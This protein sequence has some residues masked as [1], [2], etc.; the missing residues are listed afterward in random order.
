VPTPV[1]E[2]VVA[3]PHAGV[4]AWTCRF[5][6]VALFVDIAGFT[7]LSEALAQWGRRGTEELTNVLNR[8]FG[9]AIDRLEALGG[10]VTTFAGD[11]LTALFPDSAALPWTPAARALQ[12]AL[13]LQAGA[14]ALTDLSTSAGSLRLSVKVGLAAGTAVTAV[15][16]DGELLLP[17][18]GG[19][20]VDLCAAAE[21]RA[22]AGEVVA[23]ESVVEL[24]EGV[25]FGS[26]RSTVRPLE[27]A[28]VLHH[29]EP[30]LMPPRWGPEPPVLARFVPRTLADRVRA[31]TE[32]FVNEHRRV[33]TIF[34][35]FDL[36]DLTGD[37]GV[38]ALQSWCAEVVPLVRRHGG[39]LNQVALGDK[40]SNL[41]AYF[42]APAASDDGE[43]RALSCAMELRTLAGPRLR[44]GVT[45]G[46]LWCGVIGSDR[47]RSYTAVGDAVNLAARLMQAS[48]WGEVLVDAE[49]RRVASERFGYRA[50]QPLQVKGKATPVD[51]GAVE[52]PLD[53]P[54]PRV[55]ARAGDTIV[56]RTA[57]LHWAD[58][59]INAARRGRGRVLGLSGD[60]GIGKS[61][62][63]AAI[64]ERAK[65]AGL[66]VH[67]GAFEPYGATA[68]YLGWRNVWWSLLG[69]D[70]SAAGRP[71]EHLLRSILA[72]IDPDLV[73]SMPLLGP[74]LGRRLPDNERTTAM[75]PQLR[76]ELLRSLLLSCLRHRAA[77]A[78]RLVLLEDAHWM[79]PASLEL[80]QFLARSLPSLPVV[81]VV[82]HRSSAAP[83]QAVAGMAHVDERALAELAPDEAAE[84][85]RRLGAQAFGAT[86]PPAFVETVLARSGG[87]PLFVDGVVA[88]LGGAGVDPG[89]PLDPEAVGVPDTLASVVLARIDQLPEAEQRVLKVASVAGSRFTPSLLA[90]A[91][92]ALGRPDEIERSADRLSQ[93]DL[94]AREAADSEPVFVFK[95]ATTKDVA[96]ET[97]TFRTRQHLHEAMG[98]H[99]ERTAGVDLTPVVDLLAHHYGRST[100]VGKQRTYFRMA[101]DIARAAFANE[102]ARQH[103]E[104]LLP[105]VDGDDRADLSLHLGEVHEHVGRWPEAEGAY[106]EA[107]SCT[108]DP[109]RL[110]AMT[111]LGRLL[112]FTSSFDDA[113]G[114]LER[115][116][117]GAEALA[118]TSALSRSLEV[119]ATVRFGHCDWVEALETAQRHRAVAA[120]GGNRSQEGRAL[121][122]MGSSEWRLG[123]LDRAATHLREAVS[124]AEEAEDLQLLVHAANDLGGV[125]AE[126]RDLT[127]SLHWLR[128]AAATASR[129]GYRAAVALT[130]ANEAEIRLAQGD[131]PGS[132]WCAARA[133]EMDAEIGWPEG[134]M[135]DLGQAGRALAAAGRVGDAEAVFR[136]A[137]D[138]GRGLDRTLYLTVS[139]LGLAELCVDQGRIDE[140]TALNAELASLAEEVQED[141][142]RFSSELLALRIAGARGGAWRERATAMLGR[143][144]EPPR[145]A[146]VHRAVWRL[147]PGDDES[148]RTA[149]A[150][151]A[152]T[153]ARSPDDHTR[154]AYRELTGKLLGDLPPLPP[155]DEPEASTSP[156]DLLARLD[157]LALG[158]GPG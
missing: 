116:L 143:W 114:W 140:G 134:V 47:R 90:G 2:A 6:A 18:A 11:A 97:L 99:L 120:A 82:L 59:A 137:I 12:A 17:V 35:N 56:G 77:S 139:L 66:E 13:D 135:A 61:H 75:E 145:R 39:H 81:L 85:V 87:H 80:C 26:P 64:C 144:T 121:Q 31:G 48:T 88:L 43:A 148:R 136:R 123:D 141:E 150:L 153:W 100:N 27:A 52:G 146:A 94:T 5:P 67:A 57:E 36:D 42:G 23:H 125:C 22:S 40:G 117:A 71:L 73:A 37:H 44:M 1:V 19:P 98:D 54:V 32:D 132:L 89:T 102:A 34:A 107:M 53:A 72:D 69:A 79:D 45:T 115:A 108:R 138:L 50:L 156:L 152:A 86:P 95:H 7:P 16:G 49:T 51:V 58:G 28:A 128:L 110:A 9:P 129:T 76:A 124:L 24:A 112:S 147:D 15:V 130:L 8:F 131:A 41:L 3:A 91:H 157:A 30:P 122:N 63:G 14:A 33:T 62:L 149:A 142:M 113:L 46:L 155:L 25:T 105:L 93:L 154:S 151:F 10:H 126:R 119:L 84:L 60:A 83:L 127:G 21:H 133:A 29:A 38:S 118:D 109:V 101:G 70:P 96:Y 111:S 92:P 65:A 103:Y 78:P 20:P 104:R 68:S 158:G 55:R 74:V 4:A 106:R